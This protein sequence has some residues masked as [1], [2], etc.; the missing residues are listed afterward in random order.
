MKILQIS[1]CTDSTPPNIYG[2][3]EQIAYALTEE[4]VKL[5]HDVTHFATGDSHTSGNLVYELP[6]AAGF[7]VEGHYRHLSAAFAFAASNNFDIIHNHDSQLGI[8]FCPTLK[9]PY[10][11]HMCV[12]GDQELEEFIQTLTPKQYQRCKFISISRRQMELISYL[13]WFGTVYN[14]IQIESFPFQPKKDEYLLFL[15]RLSPDKGVD[16]AIQV[17]KK[18]GRMLVIAGVIPPKCQSFFDTHIKPHIDGTHIKWLGPANQ[19]LKRELFSNALALLMPIRWEEP[20]GLVMVEAM[21]CGT[22]VIAFRRGAVPE[23]VLHR[24]TGFVVETVEEMIQCVYNI[25]IILP[26]NCRSYVKRH[27][28]VKVMAEKYLEI[29]PKVIDS[30]Y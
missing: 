12:L 10:V 15:G 13:N 8:R 24:H 9:S 7:N 23:I 18:T 30:W 5:G 19:A 27:F 25:H 28:D 20:F 3:A 26:Q 22:P 11:T 2:P 4:L 6:S 1:P 29:Y 17:A 14:R 21:A 16:I